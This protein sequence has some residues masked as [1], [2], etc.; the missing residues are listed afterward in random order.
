MIVR[1]LE[2]DKVV[3]IALGYTD[4]QEQEFITN[5]PT[6]GFMLIDSLP[7]QPDFG[8]NYKWS[9]SAVVVDT[10]ANAADAQLV[11]NTESL[12][13][14]TSTDWYVIRKADTGV[15]IPVDVLTKRQEAREAITGE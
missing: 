1:K 2:D 6:G 4:T 11:V 10:V 8:Q 3:V 13:Y 9:G 5:N 7:E 15:A 14:L 12:A